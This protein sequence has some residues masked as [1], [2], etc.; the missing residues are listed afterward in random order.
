V[1]FWT[2]LRVVFCFHFQQ[3]EQHLQ[4]YNKLLLQLE[5]LNAK[6]KQNIFYLFCICQ[7]DSFS[8]LV[9]IYFWLKWIDMKL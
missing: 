3:E 4:N 7:H 5:E 8:E 1:F 2:Y 9:L 6:Y